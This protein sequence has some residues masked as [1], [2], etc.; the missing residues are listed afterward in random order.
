M[1]FI[2]TALKQDQR[3]LKQQQEN[4]SYFPDASFSATEIDV[5]RPHIKRILNRQ[6]CVY[7]KQLL[8]RL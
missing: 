1:P 7:Q 5:M 8:I 3:I 6:S 2:K 4:L